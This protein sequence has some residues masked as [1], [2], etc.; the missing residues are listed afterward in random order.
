MGDEEK[1]GGG[2]RKGQGGT[3]PERL[4]EWETKEREVEGLGRDRVERDRRDWT[5]ERQGGD[6]RERGKERRRD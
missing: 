1:R 2:A 6:E 5:S 3:G 4:D